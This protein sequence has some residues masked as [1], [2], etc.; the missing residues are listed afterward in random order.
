MQ[1]RNDGLG[2]LWP[3]HF[4]FYDFDI[5]ENEENILRSTWLNRDFQ[6]ENSLQNGGLV[7]ARHGPPGRW[8]LPGKDP[9]SDYWRDDFE[10]KCVYLRTLYHTQNIM[11]NQ[12]NL[13]SITD[14]MLWAV[15]DFIKSKMNLVVPDEVIWDISDSW[16]TEVNPV[17]IE[18][19]AID[20]AQPYM[21]PHKH[22]FSHISCLMYLEDSPYGFYFMHESHVGGQNVN[23][24]KYPCNV[25]A[26]YPNGQGE[27]NRTVFQVPTI[28][29]RCYVFPSS[30]YHALGV[31]QDSSAVR[32]HA[33]V[34]N[35][36]PRG[37]ISDVSSGTL[38]L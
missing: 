26:W 32:K 15:D 19:D 34:M 12:S 11:K 7:I 23:Y 17:T 3:A 16:I 29:G 13:A 38:Y 1:I 10:D 6:R 21:Q 31:S 20:P 27:N 8:E 37:P 24:F 4:G 18:N 35:V 28:R 9:N 30:Y 2:N 25:F 14:A 22:S 5:S 36:I 33:L